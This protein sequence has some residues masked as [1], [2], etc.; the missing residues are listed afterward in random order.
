MLEAARRL[1]RHRRWPGMSDCRGADTARLAHGRP[2]QVKAPSRRRALPIITS[3]TE[4]VQAP[5][6][7]RRRSRRRGCRLRGAVPA[8]CHYCPPRRLALFFAI[9]A[10]EVVD[11]YAMAA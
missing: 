6:M 9:S 5:L 3:M 11:Y 2:P 8:R 10:A 1:R 4:H 7:I